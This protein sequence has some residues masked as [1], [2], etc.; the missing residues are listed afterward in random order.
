M[1]ITEHYLPSHTTLSH[2]EVK[3]LAEIKQIFNSSGSVVKIIQGNN[4]CIFM[5]CIIV[6]CVFQEKFFIPMDVSFLH[7]VTHLFIQEK[8]MLLCTKMHEI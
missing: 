7:F 4:Q 2:S 3:G 1:H 6:Y 5:K 8:C